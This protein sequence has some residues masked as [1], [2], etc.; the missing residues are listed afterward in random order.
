MKRLILALSLFLS[1][2]A[3][4]TTRY[5]AKTGSNSGAGGSGAP[6]LTLDYASTNMTAGDTLIV[7]T[8]DYSGETLFPPS[9]N[10]ISDRTTVLGDGSD[11]VHL[12]YI[13]LLNAKSYIWIE[14]D[15]R[16]QPSSGYAIKIYHYNNDITLKGL[17]VRGPS[18]GGYCIYIDGDTT[19][20]YSIVWRSDSISILNSTFI[21]Y[22]TGTADY[23]NTDLIM[24]QQSDRTLI[25]GCTFRHAG[26]YGINTFYTRRVI[27]DS[28]DFYDHHGA[29]N[30][31]GGTSWSM[32]QNCLLRTA[33]VDTETAGT[34]FQIEGDSSIIRFNRMTDDSLTRSWSIEHL[35][36]ITLYN[37]G[38]SYHSRSHRVYHNTMSGRFDYGSTGKD[39]NFVPFGEIRGDGVAGTV[40]YNKF[41]NGI[42]WKARPLT[43]FL[44]N[45]EN[46]DKTSTLSSWTHYWA[47]NVMYRLDG[48]TTVVRY[49]WDMFGSDEYGLGTLRNSYPTLWGPGNTFANPS[50]ADSL[51]YSFALGASS[52]CINNAVELTTASAG[53]TGST[54]LTVAD[55]LVISDGFGV[56]PPDSIWIE[57]ATEGGSSKPE[58]GVTAVDRAGSVTLSG[59]RTWSSGAK[60]FLWKNGAKVDDIGAVQYSEGAPA[61]TPVR[62]A[63]IKL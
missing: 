6:W 55:G 61:A 15:F 19:N 50:F 45:C 57:G 9:G 47:G 51:G 38:A 49:S 27:V 23:L 58:V 63:L 16:V 2:G 14:G 56:L 34:S 33:A 44:V 42:F 13:H 36:N 37:N 41:L 48:D 22:N 24:V 31:N 4:A 39:T 28:C 26:H 32:M 43:T 3:D 25:K 11:S 8:G 30:F 46:W 54:A 52:P 62:K 7:R 1:C 21:G 59:S 18:D 5:V 17:T 40:D 10:S 20:L 12:S 53:G 29:M 35:A 60:I